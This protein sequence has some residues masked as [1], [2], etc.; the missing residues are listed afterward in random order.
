MKQKINWMRYLIIG[1]NI[2][3]LLLISSCSEQIEYKLDADIIYKNETN[4]TI[5]YHQ[6]DSVTKQRVFVFKLQPNSEKKI[7]IRGDGADKNIEIDNYQGVFEGFQGRGSIL[8]EYDNSKCLIY[9]SGEGSTTKNI[10]NY[11]TRII[12]AHHYEFVYTFTKEE[13]NQADDCN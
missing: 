2:S 11:E 6:F 12:S 4:Y 7:E 10:S 9:F 3:L 1:I 5:K 8:I 13:Y